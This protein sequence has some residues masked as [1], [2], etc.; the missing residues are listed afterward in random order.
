MIQKHRYLPSCA[1]VVFSCACSLLFSPGLQSQDFSSIDRDLVQLESLIAA[2]LL[3]TQEQQKLLEDLQQSL[4]ESGTLIESY[5]IITSRQEV[6]LE[7]LQIQ[8]NEMSQTYRR[9]SALSAKYAKSSRFWRIFTL[10]AIPV[11]AAL[12]GSLAAAFN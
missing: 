5:E 11:T 2:T 8:L 6:L 3:N 7:N 9:Q 12:S 10:I 1:A 4:N